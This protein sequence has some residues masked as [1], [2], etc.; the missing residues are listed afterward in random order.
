MSGKVPPEHIT[1]GRR[2]LLAE[3]HRV[4]QA[5][6]RKTPLTYPMVQLL[7]EAA[8]E[9]PRTECAYCEHQARSEEAKSLS[10]GEA[11]AG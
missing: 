6:S 2:R 1:E 11:E 8:S 3:A 9:C 10:V 4:V 5:R 7:I